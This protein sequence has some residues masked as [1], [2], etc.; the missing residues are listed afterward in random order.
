MRESRVQS[1]AR[2]RGCLLTFARGR[3]P[4][5][6]N[7]YFRRHRQRTAH[8]AQGHRHDARDPPPTR[9]ATLG[10]VGKA[11]PQLKPGQPA[12]HTRVRRSIPRPSL[13]PWK[14]FW[15][16]TRFRLRHSAGSPSISARPTPTRW[17]RTSHTTPT[18]RCP[19]RRT[20]RRR[21]KPCSAR[22]LK[23][24]LAIADVVPFLKPQHFY[25]A[26]HRYIYPALARPPAVEFDSRAMPA[27]QPPVHRSTAPAR[28]S[29]SDAVRMLQDARAVTPLSVKVGRNR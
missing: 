28:S 24:G 6:P 26:R 17:F 18:T 4:I 21:R 27:G 12:H 19:S 1:N 8:S 10:R 3:S 5:T 15:P 29:A 9:L 11:E 14:L 2:S 13:Q 16:A 23:R 22:S 20:A 25:E 7:A